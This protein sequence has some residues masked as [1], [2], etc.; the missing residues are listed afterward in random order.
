MPKA[1]KPENAPAIAEAVKNMAILVW[2]SPGK[3]H[4]EMMR[5]APGKNPALARSNN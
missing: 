4:F 5:I 3:Y 1:N 2:L